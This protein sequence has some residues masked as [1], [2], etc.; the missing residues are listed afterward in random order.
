MSSECPVVT[1]ADNQIGSQAKL[2]KGVIDDVINMVREAFNEEGIDEQVLMDL[3]TTW[4]RRLSESK[5]VDCKD[6]DVPVSGPTPTRGARGAAAANRA[7]AA[8]AAAASAAAQQQLLDATPA[9]HSLVPVFQAQLTAGLPVGRGNQIVQLDGPHDSSD[10]E[11]DEEDGKDADEDH[12]DND[13]DKNEEENDSPGEDEEPL[14]S[15]DDVSDEE[16]NELFETDN[17]V[18]CQYDK[19]RHPLTLV[20]RLTDPSHRSPG[21]ATSGSS[22]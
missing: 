19:V 13:E 21:V 10:D 22:T 18:V 16:P 14:N 3:K 12:D 11:D 2:Y 20:S 9:A 15:E 17:V 1:T 6:S 5:A 4:E 8:A 7:A